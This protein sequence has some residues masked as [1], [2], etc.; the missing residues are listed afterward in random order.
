MN[1]VD[2]NLEAIH[3]AISHQVDVVEKMVQC[4]YRSLRERC[5]GTANE[6][7]E[8]E[9][10][11]NQSE[12][13]IEEKCLALLA[14]QHP[15]ASDLR[16]TAAALKINAELERIADL[17]LNLAERA[18]SLNEYPEV[19]IPAK[20][21]EMVLFAR[22]MLQDA[23]TSFLDN[24]AEL[25]RK[26]HESDNQ[27]DAMNREIIEEIASSIASDPE[28]AAIYL[29]VFSASRIVER[30][31][32]LATNIAEDVE[33]VVSGAISRHRYDSEPQHQHP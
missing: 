29:H 6:V 15:V 25:A 21:T 24:D 7:L 31:G 11:I 4:A 18:E 33:Y 30:I 3:S 8:M 32:D 20:L 12:I 2:R 28:R 22:E 27:L 1:S 9:N 17:A 13:E 5:R 16:K 14:L 23:K 10:H 19:E 26:V